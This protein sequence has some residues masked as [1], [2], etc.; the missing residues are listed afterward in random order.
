VTEQQPEN[1]STNSPAPKTTDQLY[2]D[3]LSFNPE[4][5]KSW[6]NFFVSNFRVVMLIIL[7]LTGIGLYSFFK[8]PRESDPEVKI[9][10]A[11]VITTIPGASPA[12]VEELVTKKVETEISGLKDLDK[13]TSNSANSVSSITV[14]FNASANL[15]ES[16]RNLRDKVNNAKPKL[17][18]DASDPVV[19]EISLDDQPVVQIAITG[20]YDGFTM[21][22]YAETLKDELEKISGIRQVNISGGDE[23]QYQVAYFPDKLLAHGI[24]TDQANGA[25]AAANIAIPSGT[26]DSDRFQYSIRSD[27]KIFSAADIAAVPVTHAQDGSIVTIGD[28][29]TVSS[30]AI[31]K[32]R[33]ANLSTAGS[34]PQN[35]IT[36]SIIKRTGASVLD[37]VAK[38]RETLDSTI[39]TFNPGVHYDVTQDNAKEINKSFNELEHDFILTL[40]LVFGI[41]FLIVG[42]KEALVAGLAIPLVFLATF[43]ALLNLGISL[44]FLSL[45]SLILALG[46]LVD[47]AIVVVSATKQYLRTGKFT[48][49]EAVL[50]V[51]NDFKV[52]LTTTTLTTVWAFLPLL[53]STGIIGQYIKSIP[54]T[55][56]ITLI[57][58]LLIALM[59]NHPLAAVLERVRLT[60]KMFYLLEGL[61]IAIAAIGVYSGGVIGYLIAGVVALTGAYMVRW[62]ERGGKE[63][64]EANADLS[65]REWNDDELIK[66]KLRH[67]GNHENA[68]FGNRLL[69]GIIHF[70][71]FL[72]IYEKYLRRLLETKKRRVW[73]IVATVLVFLGAIALPAAGIVKSEFFPSADSDYVFIDITAP[74]GMKL[75]ETDKIVQQVEQRLLKYKEIANFSG[76]TGGV[77]PQSQKRAGDNTAAVNITLKDK[78]ERSMRSYQFADMVRKDISDIKGAEIEVAS[79]SGGPPSGAAFQAQISGDDLSR[80]AAVTKD[81]EG[82]LMEIPGVVSPNISLKNSAPQYTF[83]LNLQQLSQHGLNSAYV[84]S[85]LRMAIAGTEVSTIIEGNKEVKI[86]ATFAPE[87][88]PDLT[89]IQNLQIVNPQ[90]QAVFLKDVADV[91]LVPG[92][93]QITRINQ[94]R[95]VLLTANVSAQTNS[96]AVLAEFQKKTADYQM[97]QGYSISYGGE[98]EQ[99][100]E[101]VQSIISAMAIAILLIIATLIIQ[102]NSFRKTFIVLVTIPLALIGVFVGMGLTGVT[103]SFPGLIGILALFGIVVKNAIILMDKINLNLRSG[104]GFLDSIVDAGKSRLEAIFITSI[105]TIFGI[106]PITLSNETWTSL[107]GSVIFGLM[108][109]S[110]LTLFIIPT[111]FFMMVPENAKH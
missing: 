86:L 74:T 5:R 13:V 9:P 50:L 110:F 28:L 47:D 105:C 7:L 36:L 25:I 37:T 53:F 32:S 4:L 12:D 104:I 34:K 56:S 42:L 96:N 80:L 82:K 62:F 79:L 29:A 111:L 41:L 24:S 108:L 40:L 100:Q 61:A 30:T 2:L 84:G 102:F 85:V 98:N 69:H 66:E 17:P 57:S 107:G 14:E 109:S 15:T 87:S 89:S 21:R 88:I 64:L 33:L 6:L 49:E 52:V 1:I 106:L 44:N 10:I 67:Q 54:I 58:S 27:S 59:V 68:S 71:V 38:A 93:D 95:T 46:L 23:K 73:T 8:L 97:P 35:A 19:S 70:D 45:F 101:S 103:L 72:P 26:F 51:L 91:E 90:G 77:S 81:L 3:T 55:V 39:K 99:N 16:I 60:K 78:K 83:K 76:I 48:P 43:T 20:P 94:K 11:V 65:E 75:S 22:S 92:V 63:K 18:K 31:K